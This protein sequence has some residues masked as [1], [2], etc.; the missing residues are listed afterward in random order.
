M[1]NIKNSSG[2]IVGYTDITDDCIIINNDTK[3]LLKIT[4]NFLIIVY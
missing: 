2:K 4:D 1:N 3:P